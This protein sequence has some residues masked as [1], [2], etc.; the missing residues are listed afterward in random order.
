MIND[1][2]VLLIAYNRPEMMS[3]AIRNL[4]KILPKKIYISI[5]GPKPF[6]YGDI[7]K[8]EECRKKINEIDWKCEIHL[9]FS[10]IN[11]GCGLGVSDAISWALEHEEQIL[12]LEDD[13]EINPSFYAIV[14]DLLSKYKNSPEIFAICA[15]NISMS[16]E[17]SNDE[18]YFVS[19]YFSGWGWATWKDKWEEYDMNIIKNSRI[20][21]IELVRYVNFNPILFYYFYYNFKRIKNQKLDTWDYQINYLFIKKDLYALK[22]SKNLS[23]NIGEGQEATH[24]KKLPKYKY[25]DSPIIKLTHPLQPEVDKNKDRRHR[26]QLT[27]NLVKLVLG[28]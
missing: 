28:K 19:R 13:V 16:L 23:R 15:S 27:R 4:K 24:T 17:S 14:K 22:M 8:V 7:E 25:F 11:Q 2:P 21:I 26:K 6:V 12:I 3:I 1:P 9:K 20:K 5:D 10:E 18:E